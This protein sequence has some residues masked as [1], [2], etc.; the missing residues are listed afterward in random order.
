[1]KNLLKKNK[2]G[3]ILTENIIFIVLNIVFITILLLF[4]FSRTGDA[5]VLEE[6]YAK[7]IALLIDAAE[8]IM[9][10]NLNMED[11]IK[12][13]E[14][15]NFPAGEIVTRTGNV[16]TV[17]LREDGGYS[18]SFFNDVE[19]NANFDTITK[20]EYYFVISEKE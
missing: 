1:M 5:S 11:A 14:K 15:E 20:K 9:T 18:Y 7:Q 19:V 16:I 3:N 4:L 12:I 13:A 6:K 17:K 8:P 2:R 10:I